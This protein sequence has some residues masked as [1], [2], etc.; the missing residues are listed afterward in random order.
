MAKRRY[1]SVQHSAAKRRV[2]AQKDSIL[3]GVHNVQVYVK[4]ARLNSGYMAQACYK[5]GISIRNQVKTANKYHLRCGAR[6]IKQS[7]TQA[8]RHAL[9][10][11]ARNRR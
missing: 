5:G 4:V 8:I 10:S 1:A 9:A 2:R 3:G 11:L 6:K 7:P